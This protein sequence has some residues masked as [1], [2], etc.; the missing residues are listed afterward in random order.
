[1]TMETG[2]QSRIVLLLAAALLWASLVAFRV[3]IGATQEAESG[4]VAQQT[5]NEA[6]ARSAATPRAR[7]RNGAV[8]IAEAFPRL[9]ESRIA[10][11][12]AYARLCATAGTPCGGFDAELRE[13][14]QG[15]Q[16][17]DAL[18]R[19][20][21]ALLFYD[22]FL[23]AG[24]S[25]HWTKR[26]LALWL[27]MLLR[28]AVFVAHCDDT[29]RFERLP[30]CAGGE[31]VPPPSKF[32]M[33]A[34]FALRGGAS[35]AWTREV[36]A[37][38]RAAG[39]ER[40]RA[41]VMLVAQNWT[42]SSGS[43]ASAAPLLGARLFF[44]VERIKAL[45]LQL[46]R[47]HGVLRNASAV[48]R[49]VHCLATCAG[50]AVSRPSAEL[51]ARIAPVEARMR[52]ADTRIGLHVRTMRADVPVCFP[53]ST[54]PAA[55][56]VDSAFGSD[57]CMRASFDQWRF[58][59]VP[60]RQF[61]ARVGCV[62]SHLADVTPLT[63]WL[64]CAATGLPRAL[65]ARAGR[66]VAN[67]ITSVFLATDAPALQR[68]AALPGALGVRDGS[69]FLLALNGS[70]S[71]AHTHPRGK[72]AATL[73]TSG[74]R[75]AHARG[76]A[77]WYLL[78]LSDAILAPIESA[79][80]G[81]GCLVRPDA[82]N[83]SLLSPR[84]SDFRARRGLGSCALSACFPAIRCDECQFKPEYMGNLQLRRGAR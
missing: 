73:S 19:H 2:R 14:S 68:Y 13:F 3:E 49:S 60:L 16:S 65:E 71:I 54:P 40:G 64:R 46:F 26:R 51:A 53:D 63:G 17:I 25:Q 22:E 84:M 58:K 59:L 37:A 52:R 72:T 34:H 7:S 42:L 4:F 79:Y 38:V 83:C 78:T 29:G 28:R 1:M 75:E 35:F 69:A 9:D 41:E 74:Y 43:A 8:G 81:S 32:D 5:R 10:S 33:E 24:L 55:A 77:D 27:G 82:D 6:S 44:N 61:E 39:G 70:D 57:E 23:P 36:A 31:G 21:R 76:A 11:E 20:G 48:L 67:R 45:Q 50:F 66:A 80:T 30:P 56:A 47:E 15:V 12:R 62:R 18:S